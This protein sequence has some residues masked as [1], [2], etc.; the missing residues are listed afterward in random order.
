MDPNLSDGRR[1]L[2]HLLGYIAEADR[3]KD[4]DDTGEAAYAA[5]Y[6]LG[7]DESPQ[8]LVGALLRNNWEAAAVEDFVKA[9]D[10]MLAAYGNCETETMSLKA[11]A[12][13]RARDSAQAAYD[14]LNNEPYDD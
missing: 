6:S 13:V 5:L 7:L 8:L 3:V 10:E 2:M 9:L 11:A 4:Y 12:W 14:L 1:R